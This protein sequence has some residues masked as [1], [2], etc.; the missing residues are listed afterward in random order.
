MARVVGS[1]GKQHA[2]NSMRI[3]VLCSEGP[4]QDHLLNRA[5]AQFELAG[6]V[7][8]RPAQGKGSLAS[9]IWR[10][11]DP[12]TAWRQL[13]ARVALRPM[14]RRGESLRRALFASLPTDPERAAAAPAMTTADINSAEV[15][16]FIRRAKPDVV[17]VN[18]TPLLRQPILQLATEIPHGFVNLHTGLSPYSRGGNCNLFMLIEGH[19]EL[20][21]V[22]VHHIDPGIDS[23]DIILS[24]QVAME[25]DDCFEMIDV[26]TFHQ[27]IEL[28]LRAATQLSEGRAK[29][30][31]QW[32][33]GK[34]FLRRT[35][36]VYEPYHRLLANRM[37]DRGAVRDYLAS[38]ADR[39]AGVRVIGDVA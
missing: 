1:R 36:Y 3:L 21:G 19:P 24:S 12:R 26:R 22:T 5:A 33:H 30:V 25:S 14:E 39:V 20:V 11:R 2:V 37:I 32:E 29:R 10:Y 27:G 6:V 31:P 35:G 7:R 4:F 9:R 28:L 17:L 23:G 34:L 38:R 15:A 13:R 16:V 8:Y 18:G